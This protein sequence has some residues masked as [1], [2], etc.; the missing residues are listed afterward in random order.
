LTTTFFLLEGLSE[1]AHNDID[2]PES[3]PVATVDERCSSLG[4]LDEE[5]EVMWLIGIVKPLNAPF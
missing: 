4:L 3:Q 2:N 5:A 1:L